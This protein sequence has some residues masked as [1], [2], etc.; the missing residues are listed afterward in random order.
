MKA[1]HYTEGEELVDDIICYEFVYMSTG[2]QRKFNFKVGDEV[3][4][5]CFDGMKTTLHQSSIS[6]LPKNDR[7]DIYLSDGYQVPARYV[8]P[9]NVIEIRIPEAPPRSEWMTV[10]ECFDDVIKSVEEQYK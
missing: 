7:N 10:D 3:N 4:Y 8:F 6:Q 9:L 5:I 2:F 1:A